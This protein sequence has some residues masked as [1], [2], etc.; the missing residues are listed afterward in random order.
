MDETTTAVDTPTTADPTPGGDERLATDAQ[1]QPPQNRAAQG[2][3]PTDGLEQDDGAG[4]RPRAQDRIR[5]LSDEART[6]KLEADFWRRKAEGDGQARREPEKARELPPELKDLD[7][8]LGPYMKHH[9]TPL[10]QQLQQAEVHR[11]WI[12]DRMNFYDDYPQ[13]RD[14]EHRQLIEGATAALS[15]RMGQR[16][17][18]SDVLMY[19]RGHEK[20]GE[21]FVDKEKEQAAN[22][23]GLDES[24]VAA[25]RQAGRGG[26]RAPAMR[27]RED[28]PPDLKA[29]SAAERVKYFETQRGDEP[30]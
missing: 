23:R 8:G 16:V 13:Y 6:N 7:A 2:Q 12:D 11:A 10:Q 26:G 18:R 4:R 22:Q 28:G 29:M 5:E 1:Q 17:D 19:L 15:T 24:E 30:F 27:T 3:P 9:L 20:Y 14:K 21:L 25:R